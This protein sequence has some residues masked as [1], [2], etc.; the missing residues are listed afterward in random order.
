MQIETV[1]TASRY[2]LFTSSSTMT[3]DTDSSH[4]AFSCKLL[5]CVMSICFS[6]H[7]F[8]KKSN[9]IYNKFETKTFAVDSVQALI[10]QVIDLSLTYSCMLFIDAYIHIYQSGPISYYKSLFFRDPCVC[11]NNYVK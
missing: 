6:S 3:D 10:R 9:M 2:N 4:F 11:S 1:K 5:F 8:G 7:H